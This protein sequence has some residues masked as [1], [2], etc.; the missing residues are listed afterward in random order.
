MLKYRDQDDNPRSP[1]F[2]GCPKCERPKGL[3]TCKPKKLWN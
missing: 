2:S 3:C 1:G